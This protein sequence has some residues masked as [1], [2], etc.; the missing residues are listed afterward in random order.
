MTMRDTEYGA[1]PEEEGARDQI[2]EL[3]IRLSERVKQ[4]RI[5]DP[6]VADAF[7]EARDLTAEYDDYCGGERERLELLLCVVR[8]SEHLHRFRNDAIS[9][10]SEAPRRLIVTN[11]QMDRMME[12]VS[13]GKK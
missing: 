2:G 6:I 10:L 8:L 3:E 11:E 7:G 4:L 13:G 9:R 1:T 5:T 12:I